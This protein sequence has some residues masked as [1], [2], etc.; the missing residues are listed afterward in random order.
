MNT[1]SGNASCHLRRSTLDI[2]DPEKTTLLSGGSCGFSLPSSQSNAPS[3]A[4]ISS[5]VALQQSVVAPASA[6]LAMS[7]SG[8]ANSL[9]SSITVS[10][11]VIRGR[12][13]SLIAAI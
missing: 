4:G 10:A 5:P 13:M 11:P 1:V 3:L 6:R 2:T 8:I 7:L 12:Y 9:G